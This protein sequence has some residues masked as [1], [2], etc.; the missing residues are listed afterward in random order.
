MDVSAKALSDVEAL[1]TQ[2]Q[3]AVTAHAPQ[4]WEIA[5]TVTRVDAAQ[6]LFGVVICLVVF[7]V[8]TCFATYSFKKYDQA[9][10]D[11]EFVPGFVCFAS[12]IFS[13]VSGV[14]FLIGITNVWGWIG[15][16]LPQIVIAHQ[17][18]QKVLGQ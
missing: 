11:V 9:R 16:F 7:I 15:L 12:S 10:W 4:A 3:K 17:A 14:M 1:A 5:K 8:C 13:T 18:M 6:D 2:L